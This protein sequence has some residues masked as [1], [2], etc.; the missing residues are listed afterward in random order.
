[1][2]KTA[3]IVVDMLNPYA[4]EDADALASS[5]RGQLGRMVAL[6]D[7]ARRREDVLLAYVNDNGNAWAAGREALVEH[8]LSGEYPDLV[9]PIV[10]DNTVPFLAKG[11]H[12]IFYQTALDHLLRIEEVERVILVGQVTEQCILYSALD[13]YLRGYEISVPLDAIAHIHEDLATAALCMMEAN[14]HVDVAPS[15]T[16]F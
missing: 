1:V 4:H 6:R 15:A 8:A 16:V 2:P 5:V 3:L 9:E 12:S 7:E 10:P 14:M 13:A 11:R